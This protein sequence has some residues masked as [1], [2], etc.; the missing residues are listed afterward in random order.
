MIDILKD[1]LNSSDTFQGKPF[2]VKEVKAIKK[3]LEDTYLNALANHDVDLIRTAF[4]T[5]K[6]SAGIDKEVTRK[7]SLKVTSAEFFKYK[8]RH[9]K[10]V[11]K[12][13][14]LD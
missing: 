14:R 4:G 8:L 12:G 5:L 3:I 9:A 10:I 11:L 2:T 7:N 6:A 1:S 13:K